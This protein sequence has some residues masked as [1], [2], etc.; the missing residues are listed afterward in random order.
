MD[1][2]R[3]DKPAH[4]VIEPGHNGM[5]VAKLATDQPK[6]CRE[7]LRSVYMATPSAQRRV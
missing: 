4:L 3:L 2:G 1:G 7:F 5:N 6:R